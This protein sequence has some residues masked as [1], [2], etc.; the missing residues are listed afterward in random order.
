MANVLH[1]PEVPDGDPDGWGHLDEPEVSV[2]VDADAVA[3]AE[4]RNKATL[5]SSE[6]S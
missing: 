4:L 2:D 3:N 6:K 5:W 1:P